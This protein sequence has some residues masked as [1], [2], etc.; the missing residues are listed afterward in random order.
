MPIVAAEVLSFSPPPRC[1]KCSVGILPYGRG[2]PFAVDA[3]G[4]VYCRDHGDLVDPS[5]SQRREA[6]A[7]EL[8]AR[9]GEAIRTLEEMVVEGAE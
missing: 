8:K 9:Q 6:Y 7:A 3:E 1:P 5:Y 2:E 4:R